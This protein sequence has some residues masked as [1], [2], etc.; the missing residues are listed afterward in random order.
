MLW[1]L[2]ISAVQILQIL[3]S[4]TYV[5]REEMQE[6]KKD[7]EKVKKD[8]ESLPTGDQVHELKLE[9]ADVRG[10]IKELRAALVPVNHLAQLLLEQQLNNDSKK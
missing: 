2:V 4:K 9:L 10:E 7:L 6:V 5:K 1:A 8:I 3:L